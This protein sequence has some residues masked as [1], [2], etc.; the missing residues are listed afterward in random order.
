MAAADVS[1]SVRCAVQ[2]P[3]EG[4]TMSPILLGVG[5]LNPGLGARR[6]PIT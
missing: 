2:P 5:Y 1:H 4:T 6:A 3:T